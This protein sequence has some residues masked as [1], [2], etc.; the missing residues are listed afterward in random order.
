M[1]LSVRFAPK[2]TAKSSAST[3]AKP[4]Q[5][6]SRQL[7]LPYRACAGNCHYAHRMGPLIREPRRAS[8]NDFGPSR[9]DTDMACRSGSSLRNV[10]LAAGVE[11]CSWF[12]ARGCLWFSRTPG[13]G[14]VDC[15]DNR[16]SARVDVNVLDDDSLRIRCLRKVWYLWRGVHCGVTIDA[17]PRNECRRKQLGLRSEG[18][19]FRTV[20]CTSKNGIVDRLQRQARAMRALILTLSVLGI[21]VGAHSAEAGLN[22]TPRE[23]PASVDSATLLTDVANRRTEDRIGLSKTNRREVQRRLTR[24]GFGTKINGKFDDSTR[25]A[26]GRWQE[27]HAYPKT[28]F[29]NTAQHEALLSEGV[30]TEA[31]KS[32]H[33]D[34]RRARGRAHNSRRAGGPIGAIG[35]A[36]HHVVGGVV[37][38]FHR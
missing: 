6:S 32:D 7:L 21:V 9:L 18:L 30:P 26:I 19:K 33:Q 5:L 22:T 2:A 3:A 23:T 16:L 36:V 15:T 12:G 4:E 14:M 11:V 8:G 35:G 27:E 1:P 28:G 20:R 37:G 10:S 17:R 34:R 38:L 31:D 25:D 29:L 24:L 13:P